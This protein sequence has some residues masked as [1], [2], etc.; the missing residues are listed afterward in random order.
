MMNNFLLYKIFREISDSTRRI[1]E[2]KATESAFR[3][4]PI[5]VIDQ[6]FNYIINKFQ[7][8][9]LFASPEVG[10]N[11]FEVNAGIFLGNIEKNSKIITSSRQAFNHEG[12]FGIF[13]K[14]FSEDAELQKTLEDYLLL[15]DEK[16]HLRVANCKILRK[17]WFVRG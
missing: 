6:F 12:K 1:I 17:K 11:M 10:H 9:K 16:G 3:S 5:Q 14:T 4:C 7:I 2:Q 15:I 13:V 8:I